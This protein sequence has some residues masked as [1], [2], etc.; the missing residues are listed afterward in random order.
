LVEEPEILSTQN[1]EQ[2]FNFLDKFAFKGSKKSPILPVKRPAPPMSKVTKSPLKKS[3]SLPFSNLFI[4]G[5]SNTIEIDIDTTASN[6][7]DSL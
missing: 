6:S 7:K 4:G 5:R 2:K 1:P 3:D